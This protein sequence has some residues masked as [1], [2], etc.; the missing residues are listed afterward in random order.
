MKRAAG[1]SGGDAM[2]DIKRN[3]TSWCRVESVSALLI[4]SAMSA[5]V[6]TLILLGAG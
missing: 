2:K 3:W 1:Q 4:T 6:P 5:A